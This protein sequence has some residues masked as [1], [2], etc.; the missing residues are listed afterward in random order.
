MTFYDARYLHQPQQ[1]SQRLLRDNGSMAD[2]GFC[3]HQMVEQSSEP[4][5]FHN[6]QRYS[7]F[8]S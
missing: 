5:S 6:L 7:G 2:G 4:F 1:F 8:L 3:G